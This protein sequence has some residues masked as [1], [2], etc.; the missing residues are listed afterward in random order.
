MFSKI[1][2]VTEYIESE[3]IEFFTDLLAKYFLEM[4]W[5]FLFLPSLS[6]YILSCGVMFVQLP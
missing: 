4:M 5:W 6:R 2:S 1:V 3:Y